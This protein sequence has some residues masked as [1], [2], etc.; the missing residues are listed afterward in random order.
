M[1]NESFKSVADIFNHRVGST[2][3]STAMWGRRG[4]RWE[5]MTWADVAARVRNIACGLHALDIKQE[6]RVAI[7]CQTRPEWVCV[8][9]GILCATG[10]TTTLYPSSSS[11]EALHILNDSE[12]AFCFVE[13]E[14]QATMLAELA[15]KLPHLQRVIVVDGCESNEFQIGL[16]ELESIGLGWYHDN[17]SQY[18][19]R[20]QGIHSDQLATLIY[21]SGTTGPPKGVMLTH[22]NW[23]FESEAIDKLAILQPE[24][25]H[26]LF[27]PLAHAFAKVLQIGFIRLGVPTV[28]DGNL[29][30]LMDNLAE[31]QP[32]VLGA[33]PRVFEKAYNAIHTRAREAGGTRLKM[34]NWAMGVGQEVSELRQQ[35]QEPSGALAVQFRM[36]NR[37]VFSKLKNQFGGRIKY[38]VS[39][40]APLSKEIA[41]FFHAADLLI[42]EGY[43]LTESS[44]ASVVNRPDTYRFGSV[45]L[46]IPGVEIRIEKDGEVLLGGRGIMRGYHN[47]PEA[48]AEILTEDGWLRTGDI[49]HLEEDFLR[50]TDRKKDII[51]TAGGKNIAPQNFENQLKASSRW[52]SQVVLHGDKRPYCVAL[53]SVDMEA[54]KGWASANNL[55]TPSPH[56]LSDHPAIHDLIW[57]D[58]QALNA[59]RASYEKVKKIALLDYEISQESGELTPTLKVKRRAVEERHRELLDS[60]YED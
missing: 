59:R 58:V 20:V 8:D 33:V 9:L 16:E 17:P 50:I 3:D 60:L 36:A 51:V 52:V 4:D 1:L 18:E 55:A 54:I 57:S 44:A 29:E 47:Q 40:G 37:L 2:P 38:F 26:Y 53:I 13:T 10:C 11:E 48:T 35:G 24:D 7:L 14:S 30:R 56:E 12:S 46:A 19:M 23:V 34:F 27:L 32:T 45:G 39:G 31:T 25:K 41:E 21:T 49:G 6:Q 15:S 43:G 5:A 22:D 28:V 42:L